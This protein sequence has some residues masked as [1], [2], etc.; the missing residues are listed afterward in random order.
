M[1]DLLYV[2]EI[3][4]IKISSSIRIIQKCIIKIK[5]NHYKPGDVGGSGPERV[6]NV[7]SFLSSFTVSSFSKTKVAFD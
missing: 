1:V 5:N 7:L 3:D 2:E 6:E 4:L